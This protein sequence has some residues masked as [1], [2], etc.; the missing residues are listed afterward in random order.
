MDRIGKG[1]WQIDYTSVTGGEKICIGNQELQ[2][3][4]APGHTD[5][6]MGLLHVNTNTLVVGD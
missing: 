6:H 1:N 4:F 2:V 3:V 5:G